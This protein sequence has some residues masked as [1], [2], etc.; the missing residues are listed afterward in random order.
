MGISAVFVFKAFKAFLNNDE[1]VFILPSQHP[2]T[3]SPMKK[4]F[5]T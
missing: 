5:N 3:Q 1:I 4:A 2:E